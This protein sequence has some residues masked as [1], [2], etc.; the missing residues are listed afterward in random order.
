MANLP[1]AV[2]RSVTI[3]EGEGATTTQVTY[4]AS[5]Y[6]VETGATADAGYVLTTTY[7]NNGTN[8]PSATASEKAVNTDGA[9]ITIINTEI[10]GVTLPSTG[11]PG[12]A[13]YSLG[14]LGLMSLALALLLRRRNERK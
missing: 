8:D 5:Y 2:I 4:T 14:G 12:T 7:S 9:S 6:V 1:Q 10:A 13:L 3:G 11:G